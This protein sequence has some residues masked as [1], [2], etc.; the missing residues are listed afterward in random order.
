MW[1]GR[2]IRELLSALLAVTVVLYQVGKSAFLQI[3]GPKSRGRKCHED[4]NLV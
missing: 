3:G 4:G 2:D 1:T